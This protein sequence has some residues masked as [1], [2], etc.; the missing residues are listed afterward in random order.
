MIYIFT[1][2]AWPGWIEI[3]GKEFYDRTLREMREW[4]DR[5]GIPYHGVT[6]EKIPCKFIID[7]R[8]LNPNLIT[9]SR[10]IEIVENSE[11]DLYGKT[12][13]GGR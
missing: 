5:W 4:L 3:D 2:R 6:H 10:I 8:A 7:D 12:R 11:S 13:K 9:W 1:T